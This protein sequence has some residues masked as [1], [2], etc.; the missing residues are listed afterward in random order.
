MRET[1]LFWLSHLPLAPSQIRSDII[2]SMTYLL[3]VITG[4]QTLL[5][6]MARLRPYKWELPSKSAVAKQYSNS[7]TF[8]YFFYCCSTRWNSPL[9]WPISSL[10]LFVSLLFIDFSIHLF[11]SLFLAY[12]ASNYRLASQQAD[13]GVLDFLLFYPIV[14]RYHH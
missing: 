3:L 9:I 4:P 1:F 7:R 2:P 8:L 6:T 13:S 11:V 14:N 10:L 5:H 12:L